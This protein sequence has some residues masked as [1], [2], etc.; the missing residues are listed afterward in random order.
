MTRNA[1]GTQEKRNGKCLFFLCDLKRKDLF[2]IPVGSVPALNT[3]RREKQSGPGA[4]NPGAFDS[5]PFSL[6][7]PTKE[8]RVRCDK[9][10]STIDYI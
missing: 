2:S 4:G 9:V 3:I 6:K 10:K 8:F 7:N 1:S 5:D